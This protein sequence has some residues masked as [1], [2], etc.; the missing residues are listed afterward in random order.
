MEIDDLSDDQLDQL[1]SKLA[2]RLPTGRH[3]DKIVTTRR[4]LLAAAAGGSAGVA[5]LVKLGIDPATAQQ[6]AGQVGTPSSPEDVFAF[7][8]DVQG[9]L[10]GGGPLSDG[11]GTERQIWIIANGA[12]DPSGADADDIIFE[13]ES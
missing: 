5:A 10:N 7:D 9:S 4:Q 8:L 2:G 11:D 1:A 3:G 6:A 12:S 13:E